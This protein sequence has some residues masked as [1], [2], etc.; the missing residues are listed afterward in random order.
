M[1][2]AVCGGGRWG[3]RVFAYV[4]PCILGSELAPIPY[5][6]RLV[7]SFQYFDHSTFFFEFRHKA[8]SF[9]RRDTGHDGRIGQDRVEWVGVVY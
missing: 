3:V 8:V 2:W 4:Y 7:L 6:T 1:H 9:Q 5:A